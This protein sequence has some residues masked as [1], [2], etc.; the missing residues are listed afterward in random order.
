MCVVQRVFD[1]PLT[2]DRVG[3]QVF[4]FKVPS[5]LNLETYVPRRPVSYYDYYKSTRRVKVAMHWD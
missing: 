5:M 2:Y 3:S 4:G 1:P